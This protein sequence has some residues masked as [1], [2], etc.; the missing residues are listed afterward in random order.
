V[1][2]VYDTLNDIILESEMS[3]QKAEYFNMDIEP[4]L[5]TPRMRE[6]QLL[7]LQPMLRFFYD[8]VPFDRRRM[9][10]AGIKP[11]DIKTFEDLSRAWPFAGQ[12][13]YRGVFEEGR[14]DMNQAFQFIFGQE[15]MNDIHMMTTTSG[16]TGVPTP[17]PVFH[18][19]TKTMGELFGR[20]AHRIG[21]AAGDR[22]GICFGLSMHA[23]GVPHIPW[24]RRV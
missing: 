15:R 4:F 12:E 19:S 11:E 6:I 20:I 21:I 24:Y 23:A 1:K 16:T 17:Y 3:N 5:N 13:D 9:D 7:K 22:L 10:R 14:G 18:E 8:H 2:L